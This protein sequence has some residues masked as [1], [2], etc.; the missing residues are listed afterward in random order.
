[1]FGSDGAEKDPALAE[2]YLRK[3]CSFGYGAGCSNMGVMFEDGLGVEKDFSRA[4]D[5]YREACDLN[6]FQGC[7]NLGVMI[8][9]GVGG[10]PN[11]S[12]ATDLFMVACENE[13]TP[14]CTYLG[15]A[16]VK[17]KSKRDL[18][19]SLLKKACAAGDKEAC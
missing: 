18:G 15:K 8:A 4:R 2:D 6:E 12:E 9:E 13:F 17:L 3:S 19:K 5:L 14:S 11:L 10:K 16:W 1:M 7:H